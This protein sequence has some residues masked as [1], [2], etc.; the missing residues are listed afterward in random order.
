[1]CSARTNFDKSYFLK[2]GKFKKVV[3]N[4]IRKLLMNW[5]NLLQNEQNKKK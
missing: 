1:M 2:F 4:M 5:R 3:R